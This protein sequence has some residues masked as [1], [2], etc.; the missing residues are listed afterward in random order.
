MSKKSW[1]AWGPLALGGF[2]LILLLGGFGAWS[3]ATQISGAIVASGRVEVDRNRQVVQ[4]PDGGVVSEMIV[5]EGD[6]VE[7]GQLLL[8]LD[9]ALLKSNLAVT[10]SQLFELMA[11]RGRFEAERDGL[12][13]IVFDSELVENAEL[14]PEIQGLVDGQ[15]R[16]FQARQETLQQE[17]DQLT[18]RREQIVNQIEGI[19]AQRTALTTQLELI[20]DELEDQ[21]ALLDKGLAQAARVLNL[22][23]EEAGLAGRVGELTAQRA[24]AEGRITEIEL[25]I[26]GLVTSRRED[27]ITRL[28]DLRYREV[29]LGE[30][31]RNLVEK[32]SRL[33]IRAPVAGIVLGMRVTTPR[34]VIRPADSILF[35]VPQDRPLVVVVSVPP[36][37]IDQVFPGQTVSLRFSAFDQRTTPELLGEVVLI[38]ADAFQDEGTRSDYYR[39]EIII[40]EGEID[41]LPADVSLIPGMPVDAYL[42]TAD[43]TPLA[44]LIKPLTDYFSR[45]FREG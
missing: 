29:E 40:R 38:S 4:H 6:L 30:R 12:E 34:S 19:D 18:K 24:Q 32:I 41:K 31:R 43:R 9:D 2:A 15:V 13:E 22:R 27:A 35:I 39:A 23:R 5:D 1:S 36:I 37:H 11:R 28:R 45:A 20:R 25:G 8:K 17:V 33:E 21:Q 16:L 7:V 26:L 44:Y 14:G 42:R 3:V 10:E